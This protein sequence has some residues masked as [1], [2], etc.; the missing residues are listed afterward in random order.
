M[1]VENLT[2]N[3]RQA[4]FDFI[5]TYAAPVVPEEYV[6]W[7][8]QNDITLPVT[9]DFILF[10]PLNAI[11]HGTG[12]ENYDPDAGTITLAETIEVPVQ[13]D[14]Y[15]N[16]ESG[17]DGMDAF[18]RAQALETVSRSILGTRHFK[19]YGMSILYAENV[20]N[21]TYTDEDLR[22][23]SRWSV[24]IH[25]SVRSVIQTTQ[26]FF[27]SVGVQLVECDTRFK[28]QND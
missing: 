8:N 3:L 12:E 4:V 18:N 15:A 27:N 6:I 23:H 21:M 22:L 5:K 2:T 19:K 10:S 11:R 16:S 1:A 14:C 9:D 25:L 26:E 24:T 28:P 13:I 17:S 20:R 7:G